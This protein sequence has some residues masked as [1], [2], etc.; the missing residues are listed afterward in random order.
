MSD[1]GKFKFRP[2]EDWEKE[3]HKIKDQATEIVENLV[4]ELTGKI[5]EYR[6]RGSEGECSSTEVA[7]DLEKFAELYKNEVLTESEFKDIKK[8]L[9]A[10]L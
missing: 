8:K 4:G 5:R 1:E 6:N 7:K 9:L 2:P 3:F 10:K